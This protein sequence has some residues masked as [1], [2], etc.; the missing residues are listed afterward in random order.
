M[1]SQNRIRNLMKN[2]RVMVRFTEF[3]IIAKLGTKIYATTIIIFVIKPK[4]IYR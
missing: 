3:V 4:S 1:T 2:A